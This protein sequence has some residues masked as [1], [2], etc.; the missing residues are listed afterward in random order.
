M[1]APM[2]RPDVVV[3]GSINVDLIVSTSRLPGPGETVLGGRFIEQDGGKSANQAAA[4]ARVGASVAMVGAVGR[5]DLGERALASLAD[6]GVDVSAC[7][8][9]EGERTGIALIV[10]DAFAENQIAVAS[11]A[12]AQLGAA[13]VEVALEH[14]DP[15][16]GAVCL[17]GFEVGD[18]A[19]VA[20]T[21]WA[22]GRGMRVILNPAPARPIPADAL[23]AAPILTPNE[24]EASLLSGIAD[25]GRGSSLAGRAVGCPGHRLP[26]G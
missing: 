17:A 26:G 12:N 25:S 24:I 4:A 19:V 22:A 21:R 11:G 13:M 9:L 2:I 6:H 14:L 15:A 23:A 8:R 16:P 7:G 20:A 1:L 18:E 5:D 3:V 10:V